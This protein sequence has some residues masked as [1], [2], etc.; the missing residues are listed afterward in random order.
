MSAVLAMVT[1]LIK[2]IPNEEFGVLARWMVEEGNRRRDHVRN[3]LEV[4]TM[5]VWVN[6]TGK[7]T[8]GEIIQL[9]KQ[10]AKVRSEHGGELFVPLARLELAEVAQA[11][12]SSLP[13]SMPPPIPTVSIVA[14]SMKTR[15]RKKNAVND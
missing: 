1:G 3:R 4:G 13:P 8:Q 6:T 9:G 12:L 14:P 15:T 10:N 2:S 7:L 5:V 11:R